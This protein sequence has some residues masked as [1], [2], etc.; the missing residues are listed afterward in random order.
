MPWCAWADFCVWETCT[1]GYILLKLAYYDVVQ[2]RRWTSIDHCV[3]YLRRCSSQWVDIIPLRLEFHRWFWKTNILV[4][5]SEI[6]YQSNRM[7]ENSFIRYAIIVL[8]Y[9]CSSGAHFPWHL[10]SSNPSSSTNPLDS[11]RRSRT[12]RP[13]HLRW[14]L[15]AATPGPEYPAHAQSVDRE[16][17]WIHERA[18]KRAFRWN[19]RCSS[20]HAAG[21]V[22]NY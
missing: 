16:G 10:T 18:G 15:S 22:A 11:D 4:P 5:F 21:H 13:H 12:F 9:N 14:D 6:W 19:H 2:K 8:C 7:C 3:S 20:K 1:A 17:L